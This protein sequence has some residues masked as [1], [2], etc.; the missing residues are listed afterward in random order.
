MVGTA[1]GIEEPT[2]SAG[3]EAAS[4]SA[5]GPSVA[6]GDPAYRA[7]DHLGR[8]LR[9]IFLCDYIAIPTSGAR[10]TRS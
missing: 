5:G 8:L 6:Q 3:R 9:S 4:T 2:N 1:S 10:S 7:A